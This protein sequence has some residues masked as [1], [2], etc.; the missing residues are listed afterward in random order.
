MTRHLETD[1]LSNQDISS[2]LEIGLYT[3]DADRLI[4]VQLFV[5][6]VAG[7][8]DYVFYATLQIAGAGS[9]YRF[10]PIT[11][12][13]ATVGV[14]AI[15]GQAI[16]IA[17][18]NVDVVKIYVT[19]AAG[20]TTTP[21]TTVR[22]FEIAALRPTTADRELDVSAG[23]EVELIDDAITA[24]KYDE[25]TAF[26]LAA[27]DAGATQVARVGADGDTLETL[28]DQLDVAQTDLDSPDQYKA[29]VSALAL[30]ATLTAM[31]GA[32][33]TVETLHAIYDAIAA[34]GDVT[35]AEI[36]AYATRTLTMTAASAVAAISG[37][38]LSIRRGDT[39]ELSLTGLGN[40]STRDKL[41][42]TVKA[43]QSDQDHAALIL[44]E[45]TLGLV[46]S[47]GVVAATSG[48]GAITIDDAVAGDITIKIDE[49]ETKKIS[50][51][52]NIY[53]DVQWRSAAGDV[54]TLTSGACHIVADVTRRITE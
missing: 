11:T 23:G 9:A 52:N 35:A 50:P 25:S 34:L 29:D 24:A 6:Q 40:I 45:E 1:I 30:E 48:N 38:T 39:Y 19:G 17:V 4:C 14:T 10:I 33:W 31:K 26:A 22:W 53:Y 37:S 47:N 32:G 5:D 3:A 2:A 27:A 54:H 41:W 28:S 13:A 46:Y 18:R 36:W 49:A 12:A 21:D 42:F 7:N 15:G 44:V 16:F 20:D 43:K 8:D 51:Q